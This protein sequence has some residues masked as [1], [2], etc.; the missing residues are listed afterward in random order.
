MSARVEEMSARAQEP[1]ATAEQLTSLVAQ[2]R[3]RGL[4]TVHAS[5]LLLFHAA[6]GVGGSPL[7]L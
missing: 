1:A 4:N 2:I 6:K 3:A 5:G 7:E